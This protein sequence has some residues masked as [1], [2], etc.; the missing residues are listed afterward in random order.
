MKAKEGIID[1][2]NNLLTIE[3]TAIN[4]YFVQA[5]ICKSW[6]FERLYAKLMASSMGEMRDTQGLIRHILYLEGLPNLQRMNRVQIGANLLEHLQA[7]LS[8][9]QGA[10]AALTAGIGHCRDVQDYTTRKLLEE[11]VA[12][13]EEQIDWLETQLETIRLVGIENYLS[14]QIVEAQ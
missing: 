12:S 11:M 4:Q 13:E 10:V 14:Q 2:L 3:L 8:L 7:D 6:G 9:E 1:L 5:E